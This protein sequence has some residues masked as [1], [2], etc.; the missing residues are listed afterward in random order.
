M[1]FAVGM[2]FNMGKRTSNTIGNANSSTNLIA[3]GIWPL[4]EVDVSTRNGIWPNVVDGLLLFFDAGN[5]NSYPG[6][7]T[8]VNDVSRSRGSG[9]LVNGTG[10]TSAANNAGYFTFDGVDDYI[11]INNTISSLTDFTIETWF[12]LTVSDA[13]YRQI[14]TKGATQ[15]R[16]GN[17]GFG[18]R[19]QIAIDT[20]TVNGNFSMNFTKASALNTWRHVIWT[21]ASGVNRLYFASVQQNLAQGT[22]T[23][24]NLASFTNTT[25]VIFTG[26]LWS[27]SPNTFVG[28][29]PVLR[30]YNRALGQ[31]EITANYNQL[32]GRYGL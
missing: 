29:M 15:L 10:Y 13:N 1:L 23:T 21:R 17:S 14:F 7:G 2:G 12:Y 30:I 5:P 25:A 6:S 24:Y 4:G 19:L 22:S 3:N 11:L 9:T 27:N 18:N 28:R 20:T 26:S 16:F 8:V 32:K 31:T